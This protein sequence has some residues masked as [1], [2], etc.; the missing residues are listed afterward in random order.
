MW[1]LLFLCGVL[2]THQVQGVD[3][4]DAARYWW[5]TADYWETSRDYWETTPGY[6]GCGGYLYGSSGSFYSPNYP[7]LYPDNSDCIWYIRPGNQIIQLELPDVN[8]ECG[9]DDVYVYD[10]S[11][12]GNRLLGKTCN[13]TKNN[14]FYSTS[15][16]LTVRFRS[17]GSVRNTGFHASYRVV[18][19]GSCIHNCGYQ[20][21]Y[22]SCSSSCV[23]RGDCCYDYEDHCGSTTVTDMPETDATTDLYSCLYNCGSHLGSCSCTSSCE[24]YGN[25]CHD[26]Y[27]YCPSTGDPVTDQP[28]CRYNCGMHLGSCSCRSS[29][30][31]NGDCCYDYYDYCSST[32]TWP[33]VT[34]QPSC[35]Y[36][37]G[38]SMGSCSCSSSCEYYG[39]CCYDYYSYCQWSTDMP[40]TM[41][42]TEQPSCQYN[43][44]WNIG[45]CSCSSSCEYYGN[46]CNDYYYYCQSPDFTTAQPSC[47]YNCGSYMGSCSCS[48]SCEYYG[49]C[50]YDYYSYCLVSTRE[51][52]GSCGGNLFGSGTFSSP[53]YPSYY[54][55]NAYCMWQLRA[56]YDQRIFLQFTFL[57]LENCCSCDYIEIYDGPYVYSPFLGKVCNNSLSTFFSTS[58]YMT[59]VFRTDGSMVGRG[60]NA[61]F[62]SSLTP[63]SGRVDC[64]SDNM[65]IVIEKSYLNSLG[66]DGHSLYLNDPHCRPQI[67]YYNVVFS[68]PLN[69]CGNTREFENGKIVYTNSLRAYNSNY[70]EITRQSNFKLNVN[71][72]MEE[73]SVS[74]ILYEVRELENTTI[75][76]TGRYN[77]SMVFYQSSS[78]YYQV[79]QFPYEITLNQNLYIEI[80]MRRGDSSLVLFIDTCIASP[81]AFDF[82]SRPYYLVRN[83]C[84]IDN[85]YYAYTT[86]TSPFARFTFKAFQFLRATEDVYLQCKVLIC[87]ASDYNSRCRRGCTKRVARDV[88]S[89]H[90]SETLVVGPIHLLDPEKKEDANDEQKET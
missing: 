19:G 81:S 16:Y 44:G 10:G 59:V 76:G 54:H 58:N 24:Y 90:E 71:C 28:S 31:Y 29:C 3:R 9:Y 67:S 18:S 35:R 36:N 78:F 52:T 45:N 73:D 80:D 41:P 51:P 34:A 21:G 72:R 11:S 46:C 64:S 84:P 40:T 22:C 2:I 63:S 85:T 68:F 75:T 88:G 14:T 42:V 13:N 55:D 56:A 32:T 66:Y 8:T 79:T 37:C 27:S 26:Y 12:T 23:Y 48:S 50:C 89:E 39:N 6:S 5:T 77:T 57:Q 7:N 83:G 38:W 20:V 15:Y 60:F 86:G 65:N 69:T 25:C 1:T 49:D 87:P 82:Q 53:N 4:G 33:D 62:T 74:Q 70:G 61:E 43:C 47:R 30:Q 17:D